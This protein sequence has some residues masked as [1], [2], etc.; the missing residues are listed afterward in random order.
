MSRRAKHWSAVHDILATVLKRVATP[1]EIAGYSVWTFWDDEVGETIARRAQPAHFRDGV[2]VVSVA[3]HAWIQELQFMKEA[4]R[5]KLNT[6]LGRPVIRD[7]YFASGKISTPV[8]TVATEPQALPRGSAVIEVPPIEDAAL[9]GAM[10]RILDARA[11]RLPSGRKK[12]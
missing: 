10:E 6:R 7:L 4:I 2:L 9:R 12:P 11:R 3:N 5:D 1:E 8:A